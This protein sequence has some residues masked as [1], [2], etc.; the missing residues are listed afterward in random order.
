MKYIVSLH[1][2]LYLLTVNKL[3]NA[4]DYQLEEP[5]TCEGTT[6]VYQ[7]IVSVIYSSK[8][9]NMPFLCWVLILQCGAPVR[10]YTK[11]TRVELPQPL[12]FKSN[13]MIE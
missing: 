8:I 4:D 7:N 1:F 5:T 12:C 13:I 2:A 3:A 9:C 10:K 6:F 11:T